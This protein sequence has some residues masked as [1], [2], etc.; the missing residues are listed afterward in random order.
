[1]Y[2]DVVSGNVVINTKVSPI[3]LVTK[4][5]GKLKL[6]ISTS[7]SVVKE[8][9]MIAY[10]QNTVVLD[11]LLKIARALR[12]Y[13]PNGK[14]FIPILGKLPERPTLGNLTSSYYT[15]LGSL[16]QWNNFKEDQLYDQQIAGLEKLLAQQK[17]NVTNSE[18]RVQ[19]SQNNLGYAHKFYRRDSILYA[20]NVIAEAELDQ[21]QQNYLKGKSNYQS[22]Y[23]LKINAV[24][25][26]RQTQAKIDEVEIQKSEK[27]E[28]LH[29]A[30]I[31]AYNN[32]MDGIKEWKETYV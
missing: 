7:Q 26:F 30:L 13:N 20:E 18:Y 16:Q 17:K 11:T 31:A 23:N 21:T 29:L 22:V 10:I 6:R 8:G 1:R 12:L 24:K 14:T 28:E 19:I 32:L 5:A 15:F 2:P 3:K 4:K 25:E 9:D 27:Q